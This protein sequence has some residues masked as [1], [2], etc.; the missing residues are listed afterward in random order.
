MASKSLIS[1]DFGI[2]KFEKVTSDRFSGDRI[3]Q[4]WQFWACLFW[5][6]VVFSLAGTALTRATGLNPGPIAPIASIA[7]ILTG[8]YA[9][10]GQHWRR[11]IP[12]LVIGAVAELLGLY[13]GFPFGAYAYTDRWIPTLP[14]PGDNRF[15]LI[16]PFAWALVAGASWSLAP[17]RGWPRAILAGLIAALIDLPME[18]IMTGPLDYW[19]WKQPGP[20]PGGAPIA[21]FL[22]WF[23]VA[24]IAATFL[25]QN[26]G[27]AETHDARRAAAV[28]LTGFGLLL[29][30]LGFITPA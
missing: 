5:G 24:T 22:G 17:G 25:N 7:T 16:L 11:M 15:P 18:A 2:R 26:D 9:I 28:V 10:F 3:V 14:L 4:K 1:H 21:N 13:T 27:P 29:G 30:G 19:R 8:V 23:A 20:L 6:W 12:V